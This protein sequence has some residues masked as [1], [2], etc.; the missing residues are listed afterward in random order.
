MTGYVGNP[1]SLWSEDDYIDYIEYGS[2]VSDVE[3][4]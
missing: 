3:S 4:I 1:L 2:I